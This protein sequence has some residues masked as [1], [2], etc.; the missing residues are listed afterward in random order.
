MT[1]SPQREPTRPSRRLTWAWLPRVLVES[2]LIV[3]SVLL[4][5]AVDQW[6]AD[7]E[8]REMAAVALE[9]I[10]AELEAN[11]SNAERAR[12]HH[13]AMR[14]SLARYLALRQ[15]LPSRIYLGGTFRPAATYAVAWES[16]RETGTT[17]DLAYE[18]VLDL[19]KV[20][21]QQRRY[22]ALA[23]ALTQ[24]LMA[25]VRR[26]GVEPVL[27]DRSPAFMTLQEDF[28]NRESVLITEYRAL[29]ARLSPRPPE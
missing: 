6:R 18:L 15:P 25:Q 8:R 20:Y 17:S 4:A 2:A 3:F 19:A 27:R 14:D 13:L 5:L 11:L 9:S 16:A 7:R 1:H 29:L 24:D 22:R 10:R 12:D 28:A 21:D 26:E 23:D